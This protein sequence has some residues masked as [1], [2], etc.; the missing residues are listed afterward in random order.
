M[1]EEEEELELVGDDVTGL[2]EG[3][4]GGKELARFV[5]ERVG[6]KDPDGEMKVSA[7]PVVISGLEDPVPSGKLEY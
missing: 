7:Y 3:E 6:V 4:G 1:E 2:V 5:V